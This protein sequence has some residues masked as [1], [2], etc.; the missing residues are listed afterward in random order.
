MPPEVIH[1]GKQTKKPKVLVYSTGSYIQYLVINYNR[2][3]YEKEHMYIIE[4]LCYTAE[5]NT[6]L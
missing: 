5:I 1:C 2:K 3:E 6:M 4:S